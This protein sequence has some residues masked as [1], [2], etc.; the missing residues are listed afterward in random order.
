M[1]NKIELSEINWFKDNL[2]EHE[3]KSGYV[4]YKHVVERFIGDIVLCN[5]ITEVDPECIYNELVGSL[6]DE[7]EDEYTDVFQWYLC[8]LSEF[9]IKFLNKL[10]QDD[11][12]IV[13]SDLLDIDVLCVTH[14]GT[15]WDYVLTSFPINIE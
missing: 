5:N 8:N 14:F 2:N 13:H 15:S 1:E 4:S 10:D 6:Y 3:L 12:I 9:D 7:E 11:I